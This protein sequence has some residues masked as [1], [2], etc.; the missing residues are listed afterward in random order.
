[1]AVGSSPITRLEEDNFNPIMGLKLF[2]ADNQSA[3]SFDSGSQ[4]S[5]IPLPTAAPLGAN[6]G[7]NE[8]DTAEDKSAKGNIDNQHS[9]FVL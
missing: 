7:G 3:V 8:N 2:I 6:A 9:L 1:M 4:A 5:S